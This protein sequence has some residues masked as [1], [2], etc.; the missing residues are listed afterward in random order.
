MLLPLVVGLFQPGEVA[1]PGVVIL[2]QP[3]IFDFVCHAIELAQRQICLQCA[4]KDRYKNIRV[5]RMFVWT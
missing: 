4:V 1:D 2:I 3:R 5:V